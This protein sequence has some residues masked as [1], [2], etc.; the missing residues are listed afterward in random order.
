MSSEVSLN[1]KIFL[2]SLRNREGFRKRLLFK[3]ENLINF[4]R[5]IWVGKKAI[6]CKDKKDGH[7]L[8]LRDNLCRIECVGSVGGRYN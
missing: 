3:N 7:K 2:S 5:A 1:L 6:S 4:K 8:P